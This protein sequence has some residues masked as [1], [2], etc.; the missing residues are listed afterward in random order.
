MAR[1]TIRRIS[2]RAESRRVVGIAAFALGAVGACGGAGAH[3][4]GGVYR[5]GPVAFH[6]GAVPAGWT[7]VHV[8]RATLAYRDEAHRASILLDGRCQ[9]RD[10]DVPLL[11][12]TDHLVAGTTERAITSQETIP[13]DAREAMH[14]RLRAKLDGVPMDYDIFVFKKNDCVYDFVYVG[15][16][17][18]I[19]AGAGPFEQFVGTFQTLSEPSS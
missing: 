8:E 11:A 5:D 19:D 1:F 18:G 12:L 9:Q 4:D 17:G 6:V 10:D 15:E 13:F 16:P 7:P 2:E 14:T 3:F